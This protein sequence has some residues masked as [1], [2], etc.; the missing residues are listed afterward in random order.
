MLNISISLP[1]LLE[2]AATFSGIICVYLQTREN[3]WAWPFGILSVSILAYI[4]FGQNLYSDFILHI[5]FFILNVYG[6]WHWSQRDNHGQQPISV[7]LLNQSEWILGLLAV[8][9]GT[10]T[11]G[12]IMD[13]NTDAHYAYIDAFTTSGSLVAQYFLAKKLLEN[14]LFWIVVDVVAIA[15]YLVKGLYVVAFLFF[16]YLILCVIGYFKWKDALK[17]IPQNSKGLTN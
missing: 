5:I 15:L 1:F 7:R 17:L 13:Q 3:I 14:W 8:L 4:F 11:W 2:W 10:F 12:Y 6:W 16:I 9:I